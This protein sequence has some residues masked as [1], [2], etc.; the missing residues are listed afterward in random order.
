MSGKKVLKERKGHVQLIGLNRPEKM[1]AIDVEM[2]VEL[3]KAI[4]EL[5][6]DPDLRCGLLY[7]HG[8][9]FTGGLD[10]VNWTSL[11]EQGIYPP[12]LPK[13]A[14]EPFGL[15]GTNKRVEKPMIMAVQG[16]CLTIGWELLLAM[17]IRIAS[18]DARFAM[19]EVKRGIYP[20]GGATIRLP[21]EIGWGNAMRYL[22]TGDEMKAEEAYRL[23]LIQEMTENGKQFDRAL[24][25]AETIA[26]QSPLGI[27]ASLLSSRRVQTD[28][29]KAAIAK[30]VPDLMPIMRSEDAAEGV[31]SFIERREATFKGC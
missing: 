29:E 21:Q 23:G 9:H 15:F 28:G 7:A 6:R 19:V 22:L 17:D 31:K 1:N 30:L 8:K 24:E 16:I 10:L 27:K 26:K 25:I 12:P 18:Q 4:G 13:E 14:C 11:F 3:S 20:V 5:D 2:F